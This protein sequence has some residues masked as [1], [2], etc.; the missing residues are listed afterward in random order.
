[1]ADTQAM[2]KWLKISNFFEDKPEETLQL[3]WHRL[4]VIADEH[5][6]RG[7]GSKISFAKTMVKHHGFIASNAAQ[8]PDCPSAT[9]FRDGLLALVRGE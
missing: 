9:E 7:P 2:N 1:L 8:H 3:P 5:N 4:K 6:R